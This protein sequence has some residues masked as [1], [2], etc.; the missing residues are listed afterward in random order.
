MDLFSVFDLTLFAQGFPG[1]PG[2][3]PAADLCENCPASAFNPITAAFSTLGYYA[4][5]EWLFHI[6]NGGMGS[7]AA[8][9]YILAAIG[10]LVSIAIGMPP[11]MYLW[12]AIG[13]GLFWWLVD[14]RVAVDGVGWRV[15]NN[16]IS[17]IGDRPQSEVWKLS[18]VGLINESYIIRHDGFVSNNQAPMVFSPFCDASGAC[19]SQF[20]LMIDTV[21]SDTIQQLTSMLGVSR[22]RP[23]DSQNT[24]ISD[25]DS[26]N[27]DGIR[28]WDLTANLK[29]EFVYSITTA[30]VANNDVRQYFATFMAGECGKAFINSIDMSRMTA[31]T[32]SRGASTMTDPITES[33]VLKA[34]LQ[35]GATSMVSGRPTRSYGPSCAATS[36]VPPTMQDLTLTY[37]LQGELHPKISAFRNIVNQGGSD[38]SIAKQS[39]F[40]DFYTRGIVT[41]VLMQTKPALSC[42]EHFVLMMQLLRWEAAGIT[43]QLL[44]SA[45]TG[46]RPD[47][48]AAQMLYG[49]DIKDSNGRQIGASDAPRFLENL[50][51]I[52]LFRNELQIAPSQIVEQRLT[53]GQRTVKSTQ[54]FQRINGQAAKY[55][56]LYTWALMMPYFQG[57]LLYFLAIAYPFAAMMIVVPG[58]HSVLIMWVQ[59]WVWVKLWDLG[60]AIVTVLEKSVWAMTSNGMADGQLNSLVWHVAKLNPTCFE[61]LPNN[62]AMSTTFVPTSL[63]VPLLTEMAVSNLVDKLLFL[64]NNVQLDMANTYYVYIMSALY[65]AIPAVTGQLVLGAKSGAAGMV[66]SAIGQISSPAGSAAGQSAAADI[67]AK[68]KMNQAIGRQEAYAGAM[69]ASGLA[70]SALHASNSQT[71]SSIDAEGASLRSQMIGYSKEGLSVE[72]SLKGSAASVYTGGAKTLG[73][74]GGGWAANEFD[75]AFPGVGNTMRPAGGRGGGADIPGLGASVGAQLAQIAVD[76]NRHEAIVGLAGKSLDHTG[77]QISQA[78]AVFGSKAEA[79]VNGLEASRAE[80][81]ASFMGEQ[82]GW[83]AA[84]SYAQANSEFAASIGLGAGYLDAGQKPTNMQGMARAGL[85]GEDAATLSKKSR[86]VDNFAG[87]Q[88]A[89]ISNFAASAR[90][91][92]DSERITSAYSIP[93]VPEFVKDAANKANQAADAGAVGANNSAGLPDGRKRPGEM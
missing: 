66:S 34:K 20:F 33:R 24:N 35:N 87:Q 77:A 75:K 27:D 40:W 21:V 91:A 31:A 83:E 23:G 72:Q 18:E 19:V 67:G 44:R 54:D 30:R 74:F 64:T 36:G 81:H 14:T 70:K 85:L 3:G 71:Q 13:P 8:L 57:K 25:T 56:E 45:P 50:V 69:R 65:F 12:F 93:G 80:A 78:E 59:F 58:M 16:G 88:K 46:L 62:P 76:A 5:A 86:N 52:H 9:A 15:G 7:W 39:G 28:M 73:S 89:S 61:P 41:A 92:V 49:W 1:F 47:A 26:I 90:A 10:L 6:V 17:N 11:R 2:G 42:R 37:N 55:G 79:S 4:Q 43:Y 68:M 51:L 84:N 29:W 48:Y 82:A 53:A 60:F 32:Y 22:S 63:K 38:T